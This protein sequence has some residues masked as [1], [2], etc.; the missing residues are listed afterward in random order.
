MSENKFPIGQRVNLPGHFPE[1]VILE[2]VRPIGAGYECRVRLPDGT[3]DEAILS[4]TEAEALIGQRLETA[5]KIQPVDAE[6]I[7]LLVESARVRL[8]YAHDR[9]LRRESTTRAAAR[10]ACS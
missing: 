4:P 8:P 5:T 10:T 6:K 1:P 7:R 2:A 9:Q 3:P